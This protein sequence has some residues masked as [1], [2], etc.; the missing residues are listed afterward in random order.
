MRESGVLR[1]HVTKEEQETAET[2]PLEIEK[3]SAAVWNGS[4]WHA[5]G[6]RTIPGTRTALHAH[7]Q[8]LYLQPVED[9]SY[10]MADEEYLA[11]A[12]TRSD[13]C[14]V[15]ISPSAPLP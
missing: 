5:T 11:S 2:V 12:P 15:S 10:L 1:R 8:R 3:G 13:R 6:E 9:Y 14:W 4:V 7:F